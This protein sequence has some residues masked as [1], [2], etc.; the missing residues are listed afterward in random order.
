MSQFSRK[1]PRLWLLTT[2]ANVLAYLQ[3]AFPSSSKIQ[4]YRAWPWLFRDLTQQIE[5]TI[6]FK[7][8]AIVQVV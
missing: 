6:Y 3:Q 7:I 5:W 4:V 1:N 8:F 2:P